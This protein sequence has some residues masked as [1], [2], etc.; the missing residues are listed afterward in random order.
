MLETMTVEPTVVI[1]YRYRSS[2]GAFIEAVHRAQ[3]AMS[4]AERRQHVDVARIWYDM[5]ADNLRALK[6][7]VAETRGWISDHAEHPLMPQ[8]RAHLSSLSN[9]A[10]M[11]DDALTDLLLALSTAGDILCE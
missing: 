3:N 2:A 10:R 4:A 5:L 9:D 7:E 8:M 1:P 6:N 11:L